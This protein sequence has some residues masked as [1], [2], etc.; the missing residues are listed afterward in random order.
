VRLAHL[1]RDDLSE[2]VE[3]LKFLLL[4][5]WD[6][7]SHGKGNMNKEELYDSLFELADTWTPDADKDQYVGFFELLEEK[8]SH[9]SE[10]S[11]VY[12]FII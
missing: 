2:D 3:D 5:D 4:E 11:T 8:Y 1:L 10:E 9:Q 7:D 12:Y 6:H